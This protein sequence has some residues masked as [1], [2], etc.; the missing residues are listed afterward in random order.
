MGLSLAIVALEQW[1][2]SEHIA[3]VALL[4]EIGTDALFN[5]PEFLYHTGTSPSSSAIV[6]LQQSP[7]GICVLVAAISPTLQS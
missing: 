4:P 2:L 6:G 1:D 5:P 7:T 3:T